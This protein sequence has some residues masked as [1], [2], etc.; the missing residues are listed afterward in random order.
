M[1][2]LVYRAVPPERFEAEVIA[3][4]SASSLV[5]IQM[6]KRALKQTTKTEFPAATHFIHK[7]IVLNNPTEDATRRIGIFLA[8][9][10]HDAVGR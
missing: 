7:M 5:V 1:L 2:R 6:G 9:I 10:R 3:R 4:I 8:R